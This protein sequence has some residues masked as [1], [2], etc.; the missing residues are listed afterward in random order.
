MKINI[1]ERK[2]KKKEREMA[3]SLT[4]EE[5]MHT[6]SGKIIRFI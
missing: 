3:W 1:M 2:D 5:D 4:D 6:R